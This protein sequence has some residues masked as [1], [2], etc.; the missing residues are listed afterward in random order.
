MSSAFI[1]Q[2]KFYL[3]F[4]YINYKVICS[5]TKAV[6]PD[7]YI[8]R[9]RGKIHVKGKG[10]MTTYWLD[11]KGERHMPSKMEARFIFQI[12]IQYL[13][14]AKF[15][16]MGQVIVLVMKNRG[17]YPRKDQVEEEERLKELFLEN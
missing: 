14:I 4:H 5:A 17:F 3:N 12:V 8:T 15:Q 10:E 11:S 16:V 13:S 1:S 9:K 2:S 7:K 6:L